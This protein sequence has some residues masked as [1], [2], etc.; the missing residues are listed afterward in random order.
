[1]HSRQRATVGHTVVTKQELQSPASKGRRNSFRRD[2]STD[3]CSTHPDQQL[4]LYCTTCSVVVCPKCALLS[5][6]PPAHD[7]EGAAEAFDDATHSIRGLADRCTE[8]LERLNASRMG[9]LRMRE[10]LQSN[11]EQALL[12][13]EAW[14]NEMQ[15]QVRAKALQAKERVAQRKE[16]QDCLWDGREE[17][18]SHA[19]SVLQDLHTFGSAALE[20][21]SRL[22]F[23][24]QISKPLV[25]RLQKSLAEVPDPDLWTSHE[26]S[27]G[28]I[29]RMP[30]I[31]DLFRET[32]E[33]PSST[34]ATPALERARD[35]TESRTSG[36]AR[37]EN[38]SE[39]TQLAT[40]G[41]YEECKRA[42]E[43]AKREVERER[44]CREE[45]ESTISVMRQA[46][47][48]QT[49]AIVSLES[50]LRRALGG[51]DSLQQRLLE[52]QES[53]AI[54]EIERVVSL[55]AE[56]KRLRDVLEK[57]RSAAASA[58]VENLGRTVGRE[59][60]PDEARA[61]G[62]GLDAEAEAQL[63]R[64]AEE[65]EAAAVEWRCKY[66]DLRIKAEVLLAR[67]KGA[68][69]LLLDEIKS[70]RQMSD[71]ALLIWRESEQLTPVRAMLSEG[72]RPMPADTAGGVDRQCPVS[73]PALSPD[74]TAR[75]VAEMKSARVQR[76]QETGWL[77][78][79]AATPLPTASF[80]SQARG[81][82]QVV[83]V[84]LKI[85]P[86]LVC[87]CCQGKDNAAG[88][89]HVEGVG[90][91]DEESRRNGT[92]T[93]EQLLELELRA[94]KLEHTS[95]E[96][97]WKRE[98][99]A[100]LGDLQDGRRPLTVSSVSPAGTR[101]GEG[102]N[103][104]GRA[105]PCSLELDAAGAVAVMGVTAGKAEVDSELKMLK[106][107]YMNAQVA[108]GKERAELQS[109]F[110][111]VLQVCAHAFICLQWLILC[112]AHLEHITIGMY[113]GRDRRRTGPQARVCTACCIASRK[114]G[115]RRIILAFRYPPLGRS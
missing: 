108:W 73:P 105:R 80:A 66:C 65:L 75:L 69:K 18:L 88:G 43:E 4:D 85:E 107:E 91:E 27:D 39:S 42:L 3:K 98:R 79:G 20:T 103:A 82:Q 109:Q 102:G 23:V 55:E 38:E 68:A 47:D 9:M 37:A 14:Q 17:A 83:N 115:F 22:R 44:R 40:N 19:I 35:S 86:K 93:K 41:M 96:E 13:I 77:G 49:D 90:E 111:S 36:R 24:V 89:A 1:M 33:R 51:R 52:H 32:D 48:A 95:A 59:G 97:R 63:N 57:E 76:E 113:G 71:Q 104:S 101:E 45:M 7:L 61:R 26:M 92:S 99:D 64:I 112:A 72:P 16:A 78:D 2:P 11:A 74:V 94:L 58:A 84:V 15:E 70:C 53:A 100:L 87:T 5:H 46:A 29:Q 12:E 10:A 25:D 62:G 8:A 31:F 106:N 114:T 21:P 6:P 67:V 30:S 34:R 50:D 60:V 81:V 28:N 56:C 54:A 110:R